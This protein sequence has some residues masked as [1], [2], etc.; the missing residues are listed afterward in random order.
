MKRTNIV[1]AGLYLTIVFILISLAA[2]GRYGIPYIFE[3]YGMPG[4][5]VVTE[6]SKDSH[7][8]IIA[9]YKF[10]VDGKPYSGRTY[11]D[12]LQIG[13][14]IPIWY[15]LQIPWINECHEKSVHER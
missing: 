12:Y 10:T 8:K 5:A 9:K 4:E 11:S 13:D 3:K 2:I 1:V 7:G 14:T 6:F 15:F